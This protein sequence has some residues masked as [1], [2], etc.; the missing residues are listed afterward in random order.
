VRPTKALLLILLLSGALSCPPCDGSPSSRNDGTRAASRSERVLIGSFNLQVFGTRKAGKPGVLKII[1]QILRH[2][3]VVAVQEIRDA[4]G[5]SVVAL[6]NAVN[7]EGARY[8]YEIGPRLGRTSSKEQYAFFYDTTRIEA[9][10]GAYT[11]GEGGVDT[12]EREPFIAHFRT[13]SG[14]FHFTLIDIH[15]KP[16][17]AAAEIAFLPTVFSE[18]RAHTREGDVICLGDFNA[19]GAYYDESAYTSTFPTATFDWLIGNSVEIGRAHV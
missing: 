16:D 6:K 3:D 10:P 8:D 5:T 18:A 13:K 1:A 14:T 15:T 11:Y 4:G 19:D 17:D 7:A 9:S 12:F 2:Y